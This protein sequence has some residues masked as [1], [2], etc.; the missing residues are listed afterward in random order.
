MSRRAKLKRGYLQTLKNLFCHTSIRQKT[1]LDGIRIVYVETLEKHVREIVSPFIVRL[2]SRYPKF[3]PKEIQVATLIKD[4][5]TTKQIAKIMGALKGAIDMHY[6][7]IR[8]KRRL[9]NQKV[10]LRSFFS[11]LP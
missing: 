1:T 9:N 5:K 10:N 6:N 2:T 3:T 4:G 7:H 11:S 8:S